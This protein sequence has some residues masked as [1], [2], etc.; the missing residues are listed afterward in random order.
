MTRLPA[1]VQ[2]TTP[3]TSASDLRLL[4]VYGAWT[5][6]NQLMYTG[7]TVQALDTRASQ[8][9]YDA[10][11][12]STA[13]PLYRHAATLPNYLDDWEFRPILQCQID[14][15]RCRTGRG[16]IENYVIEALRNAGYDL[17]NK[18]LAFDTNGRGPKAQNKRKREREQSFVCRAHWLQGNGRKRRV[19]IKH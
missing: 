10:R 18:S 15:K 16:Q 11:R 7:T 4:T 17:L 13:C 9:R 2:C 6:D 8:H 19:P 14:H 1:V 12:D 3:E 5:P